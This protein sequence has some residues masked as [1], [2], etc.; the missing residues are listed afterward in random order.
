MHS[1]NWLER[2]MYDLWSKSHH[3]EVCNKDN[4]QHAKD[5]ISQR[6]KWILAYVLWNGQ[7]SDRKNPPTL[8]SA[9]PVPGFSRHYQQGTMWVFGSRRL[10]HRVINHYSSWYSPRLSWVARKNNERKDIA[11][12]DIYEMQTRCTILG[13][14]SNIII[15]WTLK[16]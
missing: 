9:D 3:T 4:R 6:T 14:I 16:R 12:W 15:Q 11:F 7:L 5:I 1:Y 2:E 8:L 10:V 13:C